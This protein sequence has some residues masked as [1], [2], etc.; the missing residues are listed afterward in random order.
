MICTCRV[1]IAAFHIFFVFCLLFFGLSSITMHFKS[2]TK[3]RDNTT[4]PIN[5]WY[6]CVINSHDLILMWRNYVSKQGVF[7]LSVTCGV[8]TQ[9]FTYFSIWKIYRIRGFRAWKFK[10][11][12]INLNSLFLTL[13]SFSNVYIS[14]EFFSRSLSGVE[15]GSK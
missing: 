6:K 11:S 12:Y 3:S 8:N 10:C 2:E 9:T 1:L 4:T 13:L 15:L 7:P 14:L 5:H